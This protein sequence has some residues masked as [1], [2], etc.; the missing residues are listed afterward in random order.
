MTQRQMLRP[1]TALIAEL[2]KAAAAG[3][4]NLKEVLAKKDY[5]GKKSVWMLRW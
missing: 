5:L 1:T 4:E 2:E 3:C